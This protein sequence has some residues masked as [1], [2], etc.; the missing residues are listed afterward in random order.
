MI[1]I[2]ATRFRNRLFD[3]LDQVAAGETI[4]IE[5][6]QQEVARSVPAQVGEWR[7]RMTITPRL[8]VAPDEFIKPIDDLWA[9]YA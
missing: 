9:E 6:N 1:R 7:D 4:V 5:R 2:S 8:L 3:F